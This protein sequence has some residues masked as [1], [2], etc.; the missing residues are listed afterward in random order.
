MIEVTA[1]NDESGS[2]KAKV[3]DDVVAFKQQIIKPKNKMKKKE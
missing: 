1:D 3:S 2:D